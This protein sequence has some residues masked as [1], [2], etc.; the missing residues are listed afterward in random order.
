M[1]DL[2]EEVFQ[3]HLET[4]KREGEK[5]TGGNDEE[6]E[7]DDEDEEEGASLAVVSV[8][9]LSHLI[10]LQEKTIKNQPKSPLLSTIPYD[11]AI[12]I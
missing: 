7:D 4:I 2:C 5:D 9:S 8:P 12:T 1:K 10:N 6:E 3:S 11:I